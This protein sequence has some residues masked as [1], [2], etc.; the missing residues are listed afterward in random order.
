MV[1]VARFVTV[2]FF[3]IAALV[4]T[5]A[6]AAL[7]LPDTP[8][9]TIWRLKPTAQ[10]SFMAMGPWALALLSAVGVLCALGAFG[11]WKQKRSGLYVAVFILCANMIG[12]IAN[13]LFRGDVR[14]LIGLPIGLA[15][16]ALV[17]MSQSHAGR[18]PK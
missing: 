8:L 3:V 7:L 10:Q 4:A 14:T 2:T 5:T 1:R 6:L 15:L 16:V 9:S 17:I 11:L 13:A 18:N 12:D